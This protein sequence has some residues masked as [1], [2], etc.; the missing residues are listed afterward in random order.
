ME[1][2]WYTAKEVKDMTG[3]LFELVQANKT[4]DRAELQGHFFALSDGVENQNT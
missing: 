2:T 3:E 1:S 4:M